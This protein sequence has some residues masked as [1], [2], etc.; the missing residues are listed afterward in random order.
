[1]IEPAIQR[2]GEIYDRGLPQLVASKLIG[3]LETPVSAFLKLSKGREGNCFLLESVEGNASRGRYSMIGL[4]PDILW[5]AQGDKAEINRTALNQVTEFTPCPLPP[6][7]SLR[8]LI[9]E[10]AIASTADLPPMAAG[11]F[12]Y[13]GYD[14]VRQMERLAPAKPD[15]IGVPETLMI[16]PTVMVVFDSVRDEM[17]VVA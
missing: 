17:I 10:S 15:P 2:F 8:A 7:A 11:V 12:G 6:L 3:D 1:M 5:R 9:A 13:L 4:D 14:M 16:R